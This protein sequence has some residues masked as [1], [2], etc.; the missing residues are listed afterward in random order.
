MRTL[1]GKVVVITGAGS[2]IGRALALDAAGKGAVLALSDVDEVGLLETAERARTRMG[3]DVRS[4]QAR[5]QRPYG[6]GVLRGL[7]P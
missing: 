5:R 6:D 3:R 2:G 4:R 7:R 1:D